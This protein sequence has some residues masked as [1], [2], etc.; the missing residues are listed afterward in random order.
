LTIKNPRTPQE[1]AALLEAIND[2]GGL[3]PYARKI[4]RTHSTVQR[5]QN[6]ARRIVDKD[7]RPRKS[8]ARRDE[9]LIELIEYMGGRCQLCKQSFP[10]AAYDFHHINADEK[11]HHISRILLNDFE[12]VKAEANKCALLCANCHR[13]AHYAYKNLFTNNK[14]APDE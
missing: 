1:A 2:A 12:T 13:I 11:E 3:R 9:R 4:K 10:P 7:Y 8:K 14:G 6:S 5:W